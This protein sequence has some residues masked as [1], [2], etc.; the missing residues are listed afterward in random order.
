M[1]SSWVKS[2]LDAFE[3]L[4]MGP[5]FG[6]LTL[7]VMERSRHLHDRNRQ[8]LALERE[9]RFYQLGRIAGSVAH[10]VRNPL[11]NLRLISEELRS[12]NTAPL[13]A[14][15]LTRLEANLTR[16]DHAM[17]LAYELARPARGLDGADDAHLNL[18]AMVD[19]AIEETA[20]R[21]AQA[22]PVDHRR[23][24]VAVEVHGRE[25]AL[26]IVLINLVRNAIEAGVGAPIHVQYQRAAGTWTM[27]LVNSG[28]LPP[29]FLAEAGVQ[30]SAKPDGLGVGLSVCRHLL[31]GLGASLE[32]TENAGIVTTRLT[33]TAS[34]SRPAEAQ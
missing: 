5:G 6:L 25:A 9:Q 14:A 8:R 17:L 31:P 19:E 7:L 20:V 26:R 28:A 12:E 11:H 2:C 23:P 34:S 27:A 33:L 22:C 30:P 16:L 10:E 29:G 24:D 32:F 15:L 3:V 18:P 4:L 1:D 13:V 21:L